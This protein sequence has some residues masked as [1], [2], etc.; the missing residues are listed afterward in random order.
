MAFVVIGIL[1]VLRRY[2]M[3]KFCTMLCGLQPLTMTFT[4]EQGVL[5]LCCAHCLDEVDM[6]VKYF[7]NGTEG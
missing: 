6:S 2:R 3:D 4:L 7:L 5:N 1:R